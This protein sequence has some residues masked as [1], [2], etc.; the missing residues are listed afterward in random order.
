MSKKVVL[1]KNVTYQT[2]D[3]F[4]VSGAWWAQIVG[5][6]DEIDEK[7]GLEKRERI[8]ELLFNKE[9]G[10]GIGCYRYNLGSGSKNSQKGRYSCPA[11]RA[12]SFDISDTEYDWS[13][14]KNAVW[15]MKQ[16]CLQGADE[17]VFFVNSPPERMT[18]NGLGYQSYVG[19]TNLARKNHK[20]FAKYVLD[21]TEH[22]LGEGIP[23]KY[24]SPVNEPVWFWTENQEGCHYHPWQVYSLMKVFADELE[25]RPLLKNV[26]LSGA[27]NGDIRWFNKTYCRVMLANKKIRKHLD[28]ID[29]HSYFTYLPFP[30]IKK[31]VNDRVAFMKRYKKFMDRHYPNVPIKTSEWTHMKGGRDYGMDSAL[32]QAKTMFEDLTILDVTSWQ[33]WI[34]LSHYDFCDGLIYYSFEENSDERIF[35]LTKRY[36][37][38]GN[39]SKF[40]E[41]GS[42]RIDVKCEDKDLN[43]IAF[44]N[45]KTVVVIVINDTDEEKEISFENVSDK[46]KMYVTNDTDSLKEYD[47]LAD[48]IK[49]SKKS[50]NTISF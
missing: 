4:G 44:K 50:V 32:V 48:N 15:M 21:V 38:F 43:V 29:T 34:A 23:V 12:E 17:V 22:F 40:V 20:R 18:N 9:K 46:A 6:W 27:E 30:L 47:I 31:S 45:K 2:I 19:Q 11:R 42:K 24:I 49:I 10:I 41:K 39:F 3:S 37:A 36:Y 26:R 13:R 1:N 25:K 7:S 28:S 16:A 33:H 5:G 14:D 8:A 35:E